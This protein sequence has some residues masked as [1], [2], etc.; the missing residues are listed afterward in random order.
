MR[1]LC[2][3][4]PT[5]ELT[6]LSILITDGS[7]VRI[8]YFS[9][10][11]I[12]WNGLE[13]FLS[14]FHSLRQVFLFGLKPQQKTEFFVYWTDF[15]LSTSA[16]VTGSGLTRSAIFRTGIEC[17]I[18][19]VFKIDLTR[20]LCILNIRYVS[21]SVIFISLMLLLLYLNWRGFMVV[22]SLMQGQNCSKWTKFGHSG[23]VLYTTATVSLQNL[24]I[25][26]MTNTYLSVH[27]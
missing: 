20:L 10:S 8:C 7:K 27:W 2:N 1:N 13:L 12:R 21:V 5:P 26:L 14:L 16:M 6:L 4:A 22:A 3:H 17:T 18:Y 25:C 23:I 9:L 19:S 11:S 15:V 24:Q